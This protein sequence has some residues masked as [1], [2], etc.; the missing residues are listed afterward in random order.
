MGACWE[1]DAS[2]HTG[3]TIV[4]VSY[5]DG[6]VIGADSRVSTGAYVSNRAS[7]GHAELAFAHM[8]LST[9]SLSTSCVRLQDKLTALHDSVWLLRSG[10]AADTQLVADYGVQQPAVRLC[11][12][13]SRA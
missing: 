1:T 10:S 9:A 6:V 5:Q 4:A 8:L 3:T 12:D 11:S 7:V 13:A 2:P